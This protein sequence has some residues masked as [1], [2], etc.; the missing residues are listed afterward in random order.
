MESRADKIF[1]N[2]ISPNDKLSDLPNSAGLALFADSQDIPILLLT[3]ANIRRTVRN[4]LA[5]QAEKSKKTDLKSITAKIYYTICPCRF[6]LALMHYKA[7]KKIFAS[8][9]KDH[10]TFVYPWYIRT[11]ISEKIPFF[12]ATKRPIFK[13]EEKILG[14]FPSQKSAAN[15]LDTLENTF[16]LCRKSEFV[17]NPAQATSC[18]YLQMDACCGVCAGK[19]SPENYQVIIKDAFEAGA[20]PAKTIEKLQADM[21]IASKE[22]NFEKAAELKRKIEKLSTLKKQTYRWTSDLKNLKI[23]HIDKSA[24]IKQEGTKAKKQTFAVFVMNFSE[25]IDLGDFVIESVE[26]ISEGIENALSKISFPSENICDET[27]LVEK[28]LIISY[29]LYRTNP[30]GLWLRISDGFERQKFQE[31][32]CGKFNHEKK[33]KTNN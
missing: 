8:N 7:A 33:E 12:S 19:I 20:N 16:K 6:R 3:T 17:N 11:D 2:R 23:V 1:E 21:Q 31:A 27:E 30:S 26:K 14:P 22:L 13:N 9:Y 28:F 5:E 29:F 32:F 10:I 18:P 4:K 15:F 25:I 24:K